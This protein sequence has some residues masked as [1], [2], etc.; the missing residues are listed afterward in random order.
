[1][2]YVDVELAL[3]AY[4]A[5]LAYCVSSTP[6]DLQDLLATQGVLRIQ[7]IGGGGDRD[8]NQDFPNVSIQA[9][10][11][12][13]STVPRA[14]HDLASDVRDRMEAIYGAA[15]SAGV[16]DSSETTSGPVEV[17]WPAAAVAVVQ[18]I[19]SVVTRGT[20]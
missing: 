4:L 18:S 15:T 14:A 17:P 20:P 8:T 5:S 11:L 7:R 12:R 9:F 19:F 6:D 2:S 3:R 10:A 1:M 16:L 13:T